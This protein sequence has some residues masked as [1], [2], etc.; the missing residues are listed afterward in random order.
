[1]ATHCSILAWKIPWAEKP[2]RPHTHTHTHSHS[3]PR[4]LASL[5]MT[6]N[7]TSHPGRSWGY[8]SLRARQR[9]PPTLLQ[10]NQRTI[11]PSLDNLGKEMASARGK[12]TAWR[13]FMNWLEKAETQKKESFKIEV[14]HHCG[15]SSLGSSNS[16]KGEG[17]NGERYNVSKL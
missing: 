6:V 15:S 9:D 1:M 13:D 12:P 16:D 11:C 14:L 5:T 8:F 2:E 7:G 3:G 4:Q 10:P 17:E